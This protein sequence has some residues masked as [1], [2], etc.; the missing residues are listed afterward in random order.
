MCV[1]TRLPDRRPTRIRAAHRADHRADFR[2][3]G[4]T[5][6]LLVVVLT[7]GCSDSTARSGAVGGEAAKPAGQI[8]SDAQAAAQ[9]AD[10]V[11]ISGTVARGAGTGTGAATATIELVLTSSGDGREQ[12]TGAGQDIDLIK[13]GPTLYVKGLTAPGAAAGYQRL[14]VT[15]PRAAPLVAQL[16]KKTVFSQL[17]KTG[18]SAAVTGTATVAGQ[19]AVKLTP[20]GGVGVLFVADDAAHPY[21][22]EVQTSPTSAATGPAPST[23]AGQGPAGALMF[24]GWNA[25]TVI[26]PPTGTGS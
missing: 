20:T 14:S 22:L 1:R 13:V 7:A 25:H 10:S 12:I 24:T 11:T 5:G 6:A 2:A 26:S 21:P 23:A 15:D 9:A 19:P 4:V 3:V 16:D 18:D 8:L 17:I